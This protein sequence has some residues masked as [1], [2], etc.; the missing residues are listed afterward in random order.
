MI[1]KKRKFNKETGKW[2]KQTYYARYPLRCR[3]KS[4]AISYS[5]QILTEVR[6]NLKKNAIFKS[7]AIK[8]IALHNFDHKNA[9]R[10]Q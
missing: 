1:P 4:L 7:N 9:T 8:A 6:K 3:Q 5:N 2:S 10:K